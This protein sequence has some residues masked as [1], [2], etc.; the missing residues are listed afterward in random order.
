MLCYPCEMLEFSGRGQSPLGVGP[1]INRALSQ[2]ATRK[3]APA[4]PGIDATMDGSDFQ[5]PL[6]MSSL[7]HLFMGARLARTDTWIS[8]VTAYSQCQARHGLGPRGVPAPLAIAQRLVA[9]RRDK[10]VG[11]HEPKLSGLNTFRVG[12]TR[13]LCTSPAY[14]PQHRRV[15]YRLRRKARYWARGSR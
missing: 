2:T 8:L 1:R 9:Y 3:A 7:L 5:A 12:I 15:R 14:Q 6:P 11:T 13:D 4:L 10:T